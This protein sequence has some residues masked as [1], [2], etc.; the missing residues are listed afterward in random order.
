M[1]LYKFF[2]KR[3]FDIFFSILLLVISFPVILII[4]II[5]FYTNDGKVFFIQTRA[6]KNGSHF[7]ILKFKTMTD[8]KDAHGNLLPEEKRIT[9]FGKWMRKFSVDEIPQL[10]NVL[11]G[12][13]SL[14]GPRPLLIDYLPLYNSFQRRRHEVKPGIT[15]W[16][17]INGRNAVSW[18]ERFKQ[19][20]WYVDNLS[21]SLD[22]KI[23]L[24][25]VSK[26]IKHE[27]GTPHDSVVM[28][29]FT[30]NS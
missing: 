8:S 28:K 1:D 16:A 10:I 30:G 3:F 7:F 11:I 14:I 22:C 21:F 20:V 17:Q 6:G 5:L 26:V 9:F 24:K 23:F 4:M 2:F 19:D 27:D 15:G 13:M 29:K 18:H 12:N 25:T